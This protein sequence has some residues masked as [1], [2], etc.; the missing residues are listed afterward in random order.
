MRMLPTIAVIIPIKELHRCRSDL[1]SL[2]NQI[3]SNG[4]E[5]GVNIE[6][7]AARTDVIASSMVGVGKYMTAYDRDVGRSSH[8]WCPTGQ[9]L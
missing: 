8:S 3:K 5:V 6:S 2:K 4:K 1:L 7:G 9:L